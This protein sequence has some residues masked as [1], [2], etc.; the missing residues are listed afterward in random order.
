MVG[1]MVS[2]IIYVYIYIYIFIYLLWFV[3]LYMYGWLILICI[4]DYVVGGFAFVSFR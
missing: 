2:Y 1:G 4:K 3:E